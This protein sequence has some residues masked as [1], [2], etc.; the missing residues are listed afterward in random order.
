MEKGEIYRRVQKKKKKI[1]DAN[2]EHVLGKRGK[3]Y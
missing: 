2:A 1:P 3:K